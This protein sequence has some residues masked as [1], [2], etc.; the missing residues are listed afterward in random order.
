MTLLFEI[1][2]EKATI[3]AQRF[4]SRST[5]FASARFIASGP[6]VPC[7]GAVE[8]GAKSRDSPTPGKTNGAYA[9]PCHTSEPA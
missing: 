2:Y 3:G 7:H 4:G 5:V 1:A 6:S 9:P 8:A